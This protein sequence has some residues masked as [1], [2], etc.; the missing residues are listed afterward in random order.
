MDVIQREINLC[1][2]FVIITS[3]KMTAKDELELYKSRDASI[4][5]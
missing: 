2:Y 5:C 4:R 1:G 3:G